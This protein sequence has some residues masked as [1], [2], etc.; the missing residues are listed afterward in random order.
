MVSRHPYDGLEPRAYWRTGVAERTRF[1]PRGLY[2]PKFELTRDTRV[3]IAG[4]CFAF[5][6]GQFLRA[7]GLRVLDTEPLPKL[8]SDRVAHSVGYRLFSARYGNIYTAAHLWQ[9]MQEAE[10]LISPADP[11]WR[12]ANRFYD[13]QRPTIEPGGFDTSEAVMEDRKFH[14]KAISEA[15]RRA[16]VFVFTF[17][18]TEAWRHQD[19]GTVYPIAPGVVAGQYNP[20]TY[21]F[22]NYNAAEVL[23]DF[24]AFRDFAKSIKPAMKFIVTV[25]PVPLT[26]TASGHHVEVASTYS[27]AVLRSVCGQLHDAFD[28]VDYFPS[29]EII[30]SARTQ[31]AYFEGNARSIS[32]AGVAAAM[33]CFLEAHGLRI[34]TQKGLGEDDMD[35]DPVCDEAILDAFAP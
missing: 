29:Y 1:D 10:G 6:I 32:A 25:S 26:A 13:A 31:G 27:K 3:M 7:A 14:L 5:H 33:G 15:L 22:H 4:S 9:L 21:A 20:K 23:E 35:Q 24:M 17:G 34:D 18:L 16:Q 8:I 30:T 11:V 28:D 19:N 12:K 2:R